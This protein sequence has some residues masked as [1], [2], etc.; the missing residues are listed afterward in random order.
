[1]YLTKREIN[2]KND[3]K[4]H[5]VWLVYFSLILIYVI[6]LYSIISGKEIITIKNIFS[7]IIIC[8]FMIYIF[9]T[10][11]SEY[12][13][14]NSVSS[15]SLF[16]CTIFL[17]FGVTSI[18]YYDED[19]FYNPENREY[20]FEAIM[21]VIAYTVVFHLTTLSM[22]AVFPFSPETRQKKRL[23][24]WSSGKVLATIIVLCAIGLIG[25][26]YIIDSGVYLQ[27][28]IVNAVRGNVTIDNVGIWR[29][30]ERLP[31]YASLIAWVHYLRKLEEGRLVNIRSWR[32]LSFFLITVSILYWIPTGRKFLIVQALV[33]PFVI[34]Y[35]T[36]RTMPRMRYT[37]TVAVLLA[38]MFPIIHNYRITQQLL[39]GSTA[40]SLGFEEVIEIIELSVDH[41]GE[42]EEVGAQGR[43]FGRLSELEVVAGAIRVVEE[44]LTPL[45]MGTNY[46]D[47]FVN[48]VPRF[49]WPDKPHVFYGNEFGQL[50]G[51][52]AEG[53]FSTSI[54]STLIGEGYLN[55]GMFGVLVA[56]LIAFIYYF[57][58]H[59]NF[60]MKSVETGR[61]LYAIS[62]P[63]L[64]YIDA[65]FALYFSSLLH[66][67][68][69]LYILCRFMQRM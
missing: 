54:A 12:N 67:W 25:R 31:D 44:G 3:R 33:V 53:D 47:A 24:D 21:V 15:L 42:L 1:M 23:L 20:Y 36:F 9:S 57:L 51:M 26:I 14:K 60:Y 64:L 27:M 48:L 41:F 2:E 16:F 59:Q 18:L 40:M 69:A 65:T 43:A 58:Y 4:I 38:V 50:I 29:F 32:V 46:L 13:K 30:I 17:F 63:T 66:M 8:L 52:M 6:A 35:A 61:L 10:I 62:V 34:W 55:F 68:V 11:I 39:L 28:G 45:R 7:I 37:V 56:A 19:F 49:A 5:R 22:R